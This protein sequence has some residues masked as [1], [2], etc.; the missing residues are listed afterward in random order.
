MFIISSFIYLVLSFYPQYYFHFT[1]YYVR[2][3][4]FYFSHTLLS[5]KGQV[6]VWPQVFLFSLLYFNNYGLNSYI[7]RTDHQ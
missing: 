5:C 1:H 2:L 3:L 6:G 4:Y 7:L